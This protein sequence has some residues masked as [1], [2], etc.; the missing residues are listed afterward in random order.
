[1]WSDV[2]QTGRILVVAGGVLIL[3]GALLWVGAKLPWLGKL[4][5]DIVIQRPGFSFYFPITTCLVLSLLASLIF[6]LMGRFRQ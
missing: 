5:G 4:P 3:V 1:M 2:H 6:W